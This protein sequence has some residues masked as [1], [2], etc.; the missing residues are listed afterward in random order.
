MGSINKLPQYNTV[1]LCDDSGSMS[2]LADPDVG[3]TT[4]R[5]QE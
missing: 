2:G 3:S 5:W 4:T 1:I